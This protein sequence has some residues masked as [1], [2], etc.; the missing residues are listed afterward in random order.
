MSPILPHTRQKELSAIRFTILLKNV[1]PSIRA[2][3]EVRSG[4]EVVHTG[5]MF[6]N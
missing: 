4:D 1:C 2:A 3:V 5:R 6:A